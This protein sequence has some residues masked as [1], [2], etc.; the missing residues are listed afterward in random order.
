MDVPRSLA[1]AAGCDGGSLDDAAGCD[2]CP[3]L[4]QRVVVGYIPRSLANAAGWDGWSLAD[5]TGCGAWNLATRNR[6][7]ASST[8]R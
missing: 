5:A 6:R 1:D 3:S 2:G 7:I 4:T 8:F